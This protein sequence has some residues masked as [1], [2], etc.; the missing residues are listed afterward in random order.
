M[1]EIVPFRP[2]NQ[3]PV[4]NLILAGLKEYWGRLDESKNPDLKNIAASYQKGIFLTAWLD[5]EI[6]GTGAFIPRSVESVEIVR[7]SVARDL[8]GQGI[9]QQLL[10]ELCGRAYQLGY[11]QVILE[12][13]ATWHKSIAFYQTF[14]FQIT[15]YSDGDVYFALDLQDFFENK[16]SSLSQKRL[17]NNRRT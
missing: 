3:E 9:G 5:H 16:L 1:I 14:G 15:H 12:T 10:V 7:M 8:R 4:R 17:N 13:T 11:K 2:E 6:V